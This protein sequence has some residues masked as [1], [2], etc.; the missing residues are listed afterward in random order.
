MKTTST[1]SRTNLHEQPKETTMKTVKSLQTV[2]A[3]SVV[4]LLTQLCSAQPVPSGQPPLPGEAQPHV[5]LKQDPAQPAATTSPTG[6]SPDQIR[7]AYGFDQLSGIDGTGQTIAIIDAFGDRYATTTTSGNGKN[8]RTTTTITDATQDDWN[9]FC[10]QFHLRSDVLLPVAYP[11]G[12]PANVSTGWALETA[13]D[14]EWAHAIAPGANIMLVVSYDNSL[15]NMYAAVDYAVSHG[16]NVV[17][18]SWG[19]GESGAELA[20]DAH[21]N[22]PGVTFVA[23]SGDAGEI[24]SGVSYPAASPY[25]LSVG[26]TQLTQNTDGTWSETAWSGSGGGIS[27]YETK[28]VFQN[29]WQQFL[30]GNMR[31]V[32]DVSYQ[33]GPNP[34]VSVYSTAYGGWIQVYGTSVGA[35][36]WAALIALANSARLSSVTVPDA[37]SALYSIAESSTMPPSIN[38]AYWIDMISGANGSDPDDAAIP[39]Y[40]FVTGL[41]SP[42][43]GNLVPAL[44]SW[45]QNPDFSLSVSPCS[46][47]LP[48]TGGSAI[49]TVA[50]SRL[51]GFSG[52]VNLSCDAN[53]TLPAVA[54]AS[55][56]ANSTS[57]DSS[58]LTVEVPSPASPSTY[59]LTITG[60][61]TTGTGTTLTRTAMASLVV[62]S[63]PSIVS[64]V[65]IG[66]NTSGPNNKNLLDTLTLKDDFGNLVAGASVSIA[67]YLNNAYYG[68]GTASTLSD[69]TVTFTAR[70]APT[71]T[72][73]TGVTGVTATGLTW[74]GKTPANSYTKTQ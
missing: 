41:G 57:G 2:A 72:Y 16:A 26:G 9:A 53:P 63:A 71:G 17:S 49:Y 56:S 19:A 68:S 35:P 50:I 29:G 55:F 46:V 69:G 66:Y 15:A 70:N 44:S 38:G 59:A 52:A 13:L 45:V 73:T 61:G 30:T 42:A 14:I 10:G 51:G 48:K 11:Q 18:M 20:N 37:H 33:G 4:A 58:T 60:T 3:L 47:T 7:Q 25:V 74:D 24:S 22:H 5:H 39:G 65:S 32:P 28:P 40:D 6:L 67:L 36:Q 8:K 27:L 1:T 21:F 62:A 34:A 12:L 43:A 64:V 23:S 54:T 31:S